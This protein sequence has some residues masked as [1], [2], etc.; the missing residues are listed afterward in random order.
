MY[1]CNMSEKP[2]KIKLKVIKAGSVINIQVGAGF[3]QR[4]QELYFNFINAHPDEN[5][6]Q[7]VENLKTDKVRTPYE[8]SLE[9]M[10][11][12]IYEMEA[13]AKEQG[14]EDEREYDIPTD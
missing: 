10:M 7:A 12:L 6:V 1:F 11:S 9:T 5:F 3:Y 14:F 8:Y 2:T 13:K 4:F